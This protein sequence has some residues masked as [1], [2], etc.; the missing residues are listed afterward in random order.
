MAFSSE[1]TEKLLDLIYDAAT[2]HT[3]WRSVLTEIADLTNSQGGVLFGQS[4][5]A[6]E[7]YFAY[8]GRTDEYF[9]NVYK[10]RHLWN[11]WAVAMDSQPVGRVVFSDEP[12]ELA[13]IRPTAFFDELIGPQDVPHS[14]MIALA[15]QEDFRAAFNICRNARQGPFGEQ[16]RRQ[17]EWLV[18]HLRR[19]IGLGFRV[20][21]YRTLQKAAYDVLDQLTVGVIL[22]DQRKRMVYV[23]AAARA[24]GSDEGPLLLRNATLAARSPPHGQRL[25]ELIRLALVGTS[26]PGSM[27]LPRSGDGR[28]LTI[29]VSA[30]R[31]RD[32]ARLDDFGMRDAAVLLFIIDPTDRAAM[33]L[34]WL[35]NA[36][37]LT[38]GEARVAV[39]ASTGIAIAETAI[40]LGLSPNTVK[41]HLR[42]VFAKTGTNRQA[43]LAALM[44]PIGLVKGNG[45]RPTNGT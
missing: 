16:E 30:V 13:S 11:P 41:T 42:N 24:L 32:V 19:S 9:N 4:T 7:F 23:N 14:A 38:Q 5:G 28:P 43:E 20:E 8:N 2:E 29:L 31:S 1:R 36:F 3:L 25:E 39:A 45:P 6:N 26:P 21:A 40:Q 17:F 12:T 44:A 35:M 18:P 27:I 33:P 15:A 34:E 22:L 37:G 10:A